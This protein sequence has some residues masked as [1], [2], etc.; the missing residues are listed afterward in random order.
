MPESRSPDSLHT[1]TLGAFHTA[2]FIFALLLL[3]YLGGGLGNLLGGLNTLIGSGVYA[4]LWATTAW[5]TRRAVGK[6]GASPLLGGVTWNLLGDGGLWCAVNGA[7]FL[8]VFVVPFAVFAVAVNVPQA[9]GDLVRFLILLLISLGAAA[10]VGLLAGLAFS[11]L[12]VACLLLAARL[13]PG[14]TPPPP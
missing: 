8:A 5:T 14:R 13:L 10:F 6:A 9:S 4:L 3:I 7:L 2:F 1:W 12:D 11:I